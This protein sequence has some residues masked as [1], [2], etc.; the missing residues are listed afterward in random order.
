MT[1]FSFQVKQKFAQENKF[2]FGT[3]VGLAENNIYILIILKTDFICNC[4][5]K[6]KEVS[7]NLRNAHS[8]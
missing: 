8:S 4:V 7:S 2:N 3:T 5:G 6:K 1:V